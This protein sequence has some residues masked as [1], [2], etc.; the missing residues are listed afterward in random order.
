MAFYSLVPPLFPMRKRTSAFDLAAS[1]SRLIGIRVPNELADRWEA[2][3]DRQGKSAAEAYRLA[4]SELMK[5]EGDLAV[6][7]Q[8]L[9]DYTAVLVAR[10]PGGEQ[11][12][13]QLG[14]SLAASKEIDRS[15]SKHVKLSMRASEYGGVSA[16]AAA[17]EV[18]PAQWIVA[19]VRAV[20]TRG[21]LAPS[22]ELEAL[23][24]STY[25]LTGIGRNLNQITHHINADPRQLRRLSPEQI[26]KI[27]DAIQAH[28]QKADELVRT[29][30]ERW[31]L[32]ESVEVPSNG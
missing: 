4:L 8:R 26:R 28:K 19:L 25:Q 21:I 12:P 5:G 1:E 18:T 9:V 15:K 7:L 14:G 27:A 23:R 22:E 6:R 20:L 13:P 31:V 30:L 10:L 3:A 2:F 24:Q 17:G 32:I 11:A 29:A 16:I